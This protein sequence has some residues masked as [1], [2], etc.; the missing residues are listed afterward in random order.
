M[1]FWHLD[2][3][4]LPDLLWPLLSWE[5]K[6]SKGSVTVVGWRSGCA[7]GI[8][9]P[10]V[11]PALPALSSWRETRED[12]DGHRPDR[13]LQRQLLGSDRLSFA[14]LSWLELEQQQSP[15]RAV[16]LPEEG[17]SESRGCRSATSRSRTQDATLSSLSRCLIKKNKFKKKKFPRSRLTVQVLEPCKGG[18]QQMALSPAITRRDDY[19]LGPSTRWEN[20]QALFSSLTS[21]FQLGRGQAIREGEEGSE[22]LKDFHPKL[23]KTI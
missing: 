5:V 10:G 6:C 1:D 16:G 15:L 21:L 11:P 3:I 9:L 20:K 13:L 14:I 4:Y 18:G 19:R 23:P 2:R 17:E 12:F 8:S 7:A 22:K